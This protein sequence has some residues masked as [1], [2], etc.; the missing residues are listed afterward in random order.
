MNPAVRLARRLGWRGRFEPT[1]HVW[2]RGLALL[3]DHNGG[4]RFVREQRGGRALLRLDPRGYAD[5][6]DGDLVWTR[7]TALQQ[8]IDEVLPTITGRF[9]LLT[10]DEDSSIPSEFPRAAQICASDRVVWGVCQK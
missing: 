3:C 5:I 4:R 8:F 7:S 9:A 2:S 1:R 10:G 6:Q